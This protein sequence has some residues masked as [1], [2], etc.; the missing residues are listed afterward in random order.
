MTV[1]ARLAKAAGVGLVIVLALVVI[2]TALRTEL[3]RSAGVMTD[4]VGPEAGES[5]AGYRDRAAATLTVG[6]MDGD[7]SDDDEVDDDDSQPAHDDLHWALVSADTE[8]SAAGA[9]GVVQDLPR[10]SALLV[11]VPVDGVAMPVT[12]SVVAE[13]VA[14]EDSRVATFARGLERTAVGSASAAATVPAGD[15]GGRKAALTAT[16][17]RAGAPAIIGLV[18]RGT[19]NQLRAVADAPGVRAVEALP[20][21]AV[22]GQFAVRPLLPQLTDAADP[23]PDDAPVP[24]A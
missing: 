24:D 1:A 20:A 22:W 3:P 9:A 11:R 2:L 18:V 6:G 17:L 7:R 14:G 4:A 10:A 8:W 13:P 5:I 19:I 16:R 12:E 23:L 21:D 15:R